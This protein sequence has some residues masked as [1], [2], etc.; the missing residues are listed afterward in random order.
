MLAFYTISTVQYLLYSFIA[1][2]GSQFLEK[3]LEIFLIQLRH[4]LYHHGLII[5]LRV[6]NYFYI[7]SDL[8][9]EDL[10]LNF[11]ESWKVVLEMG[12]IQDRAPGYIPP[13]LAVS[14][15]RISKHI[16]PTTG[17]FE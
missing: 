13:L 12:Q 17:W 4:L 7:E 10:S 16:C 14:F 9:N 15:L 2:L 3:T 11:D 8:F 6:S 5:D 1:Y